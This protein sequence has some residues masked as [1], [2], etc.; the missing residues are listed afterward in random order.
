M[1]YLKGR[2]RILEFQEAADKISSRVSALDGVVGIVLLGGLSRGFADESSDVD[3]I[4]FLNKTDDDLRRLVGQI[5][6]DEQRR[7][8]IE[9]D[10][11]VHR[12]EDFERRRWTEV[13]RWDFSIAKVVLDSSGDVNKMISSKLKVPEHFWVRRV[14]ICAEYMKWYCC[15]PNDDASSIAETS[16]ERGDPVTAHYCIN[17]GLDLLVRTLFALSKTFLPPPKWRIL[18]SRDLPWLP[19]KYEDALGKL[20][21]IKNLSRKEIDRRLGLIRELWSEVSAR[22]MK[23]MALSPETVS[24]YYIEKVLHQT[25]SPGR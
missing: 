23:D 10:L 2:N 19:T 11:E 20:L 16:V 14:V 3:I 24:R 21:T 25:Y 17:Y 18:Y 12:L 5:G 8:G 15:P 13:D 1:V 4:V 22:I 9:V 7:T 6:Q